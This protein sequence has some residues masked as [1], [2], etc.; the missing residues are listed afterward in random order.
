LRLGGRDLLVPC[1]GGTATSGRGSDDGLG[2]GA[3]GAAGDGLDVARGG[4]V[5]GGRG[6][7]VDLGGDVE[8]GGGSD[9]LAREERLEVGEELALVH[10]EVEVEEEEKLALHE[11]DLSL[12]EDGGVAG[13]VLVLRRRV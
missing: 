2:R 1:S 6:G 7:S 3:G 10:A 9:G 11:V 4:G 8:A 12:G 13:P 5:G